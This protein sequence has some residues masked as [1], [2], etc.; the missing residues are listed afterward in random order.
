MGEESVHTLKIGDSAPPFSLVGIDDKPYTLA[1]FATAKVL[2]VAFISNHCPTSHA[3]EKRMLELIAEC[4]QRGFAF[5]AINPN[6]PDGLSVDELGYSKYTDSFEDMK[7]YAAE[8]GFTFP[9]LDDGATQE[10]ARAYG[11][12]ATPHLFVFDAD[13]KLRYKGRFDDSR[14]AD[15]STVKEPDARNAVLALLDGKPVPVAETKP[16][17]C[18]TKWKSK[19]AVIATKMEAW[20][21]AP[22]TLAEIN[23]DDAAALRKNGSKHLRMIHLWATTCGPCVAEFPEIV[24]TARKFDMRDFQF[25]SVSTDVPEDATRAKEFLERMKAGM[26]K[27]AVSLAKAEGRET[28]AYRY[29]GTSLTELAKALDPEWGGALP[30]TILV[31]PGG[32]I[33]WR[34][35]GPVDGDQLRDKVLSILGGVYKP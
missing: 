24:A 8:A 35:T 25:L 22:V 11:C 7:K 5:V 4:K 29:T 17:G 21:S 28:N 15:P 32:A 23:T 33:L 14:F 9:Y 6:H 31:A 30:H 20:D 12:L 34:H 1:N 3:A 10:V 18:S 26:S 13:R 27:R 16:M 2:M 19:R